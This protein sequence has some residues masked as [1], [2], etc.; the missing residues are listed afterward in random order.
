[1][2]GIRNITLAK[3]CG[4]FLLLMLA[5]M[6]SMHINRPDISASVNLDQPF[7]YTKQTINL[8][9]FL[10]ETSENTNPGLNW[11]L[12]QWHPAPKSSLDSPCFITKGYAL[13]KTPFDWSTVHIRKHIVNC[14][15]RI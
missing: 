15:F 10:P 4:Q 5:F 14:I 9:P 13:F 6:L 8:V 7:S 3:N 12:I 2:L 1:M 11:I